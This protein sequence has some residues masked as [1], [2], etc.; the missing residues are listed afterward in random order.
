M[1]V[2]I[3][4]VDSRRRSRAHIVKLE[5]NQLILEF[6]I[7]Y[8]Y[9]VDFR[10][11]FADVVVFLKEDAVLHFKLLFKDRRRTSRLRC[12]GT[13]LLLVRLANSRT[14]RPVPH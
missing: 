8:A 1:R 14:T 3:P 12:A 4:Q 10:L 13:S 9:L 6:L 5:H 7:L 2:S 11:K